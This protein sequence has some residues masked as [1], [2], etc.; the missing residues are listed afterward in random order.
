MIDSTGKQSTMGVSSEGMKF[1]FFSDAVRPFSADVLTSRV[2]YLHFFLIRHEKFFLDGSKYNKPTR[3]LRSLVGVSFFALPPPFIMSALI[4][5]TPGSLN[6]QHVE[7]T[8]GV[9]YI[10]YVVSMSKLHLSRK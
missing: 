8:L 10:G 2:S 5:T 3:A 6:L 7:A 9:F 1:M 4:P